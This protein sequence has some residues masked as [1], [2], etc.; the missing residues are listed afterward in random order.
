VVPFLAVAPGIRKVTHATIAA[1]ALNRSLRKIIETRD[2]FPN[3]EAAL[4]LLYPAIK[5]AGIGMKWRQAIEWTSFMGQFAIHFGD[6]FPES[7][8]RPQKYHRRCHVTQ[9][10]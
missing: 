7:A 6:H 5:S 1:E 8:C 3:N 9:D 4:T 2:S 10:L